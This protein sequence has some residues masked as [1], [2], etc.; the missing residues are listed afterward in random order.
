MTA[1][2]DVVTELGYGTSGRRMDVHCPAPSSSAAPVVL[3]WHGRG[4]D[5]RDVLAPLARSAARLGVVT[6]VPDWRPDAPDGGRTQLAE[7][8]AFV[9]ENAARFGGDAERMVL[10]GWS[11]GANAVLGV[12]LNPAA[13]DGWRPRA[14][15]GIAGGYRSAAPTTGTVPIEDASR[16]G[17]PVPPIPVHLVHGTTDPITDIEQSRELRDALEERGWPAPLEELATD[18]AGIVL[19]EYS[20]E[21]QRCLPSTGAH[22]VDAG[23]RTAHLLARAAGIAVS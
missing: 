14:V 4:P 3:L 10:A 18:H 19:T 11:L 2:V 20:V 23:T 21:H 16:A 22:A 17:D 7:S 15:V 13:L 5:E 8:V 6:F 12:A 1:D 9:R